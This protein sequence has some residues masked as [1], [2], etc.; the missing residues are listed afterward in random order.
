M[1]PLSHSQVLAIPIASVQLPAKSHFYPYH[2]LVPFQLSSS[3]PSTS[4]M[5]NFAASLPTLPP[6]FR[7]HVVSENIHDILLI[8]SII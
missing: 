4:I 6:P 5:Q 3:H 7:F 1:P 8:Y 2:T